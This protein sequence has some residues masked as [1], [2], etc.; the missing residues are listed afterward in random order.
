VRELRKDPRARPLDEA[1]V[2]ID[3]MGEGFLEVLVARDIGVG[4]VGVFV[5]HD[6]HG[7]DI[8]SEV[9]LIVKVGGARPF[10]T[11]GAIRHRGSRGTSHFY[12]VEFVGLSPEQR[13]IIGKYVDACLRA[14][15]KVL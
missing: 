3:I 5:P 15:R 11:R 10:K 14:G 4:G 6:F 12:G 1:P 7:C 13:E 9:D 8:D 2:R